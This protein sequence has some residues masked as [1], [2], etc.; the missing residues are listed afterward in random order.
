MT[1]GWWNMACWNGLSTEQQQRLIHVGN[2]E[3]GYEPTG[4]CPN[5]AQVAIEM[6]RDA[7]PG[8]R[9][10]CLPC[11]IEDLKSAEADSARPA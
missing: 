8:P 9:F 5:P 7:A 11:A 1:R 2:L 3:F 10:Y 6:E 4:D